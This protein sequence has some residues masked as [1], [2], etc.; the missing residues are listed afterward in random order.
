MPFPLR[1]IYGEGA[2]LPR[3]PP[4]HPYYRDFLL[5]ATS[6]NVTITTNIKR[7]N[8]AA[9]Y[10]VS[11]VY[12]N[13]YVCVCGAQWCTLCTYDTKSMLTG[14]RCSTSCHM[15]R[16]TSVEVH[17][18]LFVVVHVARDTNNHTRTQ[19]IQPQ[20]IIAQSFMQK[21][22]FSFVH[23]Q[24]GT[25]SGNVRRHFCSHCTNACSTLEVLQLGAI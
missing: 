6:T 2:S 7:R 18:N 22:T 4:L 9:Y 5:G 21:S 15:V 19:T 3:P 1:N 20:S 17:V 25:L 11:T 10:S 14:S 13:V 23:W 24:G 8:I 16:R 12:D